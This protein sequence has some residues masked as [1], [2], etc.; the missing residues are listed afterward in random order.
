V[1]FEG[2]DLAMLPDHELAALRL[3]SFGFVFQQ[4]NLIPTLTAVENV[5]AK[6]APTASAIRISAIARSHCSTRSGSQSARSIYPPTCPAASS[7][8]LRS[9]FRDGHC[10]VEHHPAPGSFL[11]P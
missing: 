10:R 9:G 7:S 3:R 2:S 1:L 4:F 8:G 6:L 5:E 11:F